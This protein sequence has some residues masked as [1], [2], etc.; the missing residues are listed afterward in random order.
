MTEAGF[1]V[2]SGIEE[3]KDFTKSIAGVVP[4]PTHYRVLELNKSYT[5]EEIKREL[6]KFSSY[7]TYLYALIG[8]MDAE[9]IVVSKGLKKG[10]SIARIDPS[11]DKQLSLTDREAQILATSPDFAKYTKMDIIG[12]AC[13]QVLKGW[14]KSYEAA[15][16]GASRMLSADEAE[17]QAISSR[18]S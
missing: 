17:A 4:D 14:A 1:S 2:E 18:V 15:Y 8:E 16:T 12:E 7:L 3:V 9:H 6:Q 10:M 13:L 11:F 5:P